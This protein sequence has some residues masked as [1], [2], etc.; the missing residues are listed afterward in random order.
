MFLVDMNEGRIIE[1]IWNQ[2]I[3]KTSIQKMAK[4]QLITKVPYN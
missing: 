2:N 4:W 3:N 1:D